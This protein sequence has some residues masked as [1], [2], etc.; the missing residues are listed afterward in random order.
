MALTHSDFLLT[1]EEL[2]EINRYFS[3]KAESHAAAGEDAPQSVGVTFEFM[4]AFGRTV[5]ARFDGEL[6]GRV[7]SDESEVQTS[8]SKNG[9]THSDSIAES[10]HE[11]L[12]KHGFFISD[13]IKGS[14]EA[15]ELARTFADLIKSMQ[16]G[17]T[18]KG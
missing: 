16:E 10:G 17:K 18:D 8:D 4:P 14:P 1:D 2:N 11:R 13:D 15:D 9:D 3:A 7:I 6:N 5:T 12:A